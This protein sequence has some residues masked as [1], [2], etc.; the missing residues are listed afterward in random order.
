M[1]VMGNGHGRV[2]CPC[3]T[4]SKLMALILMDQSEK[5]IGV[6]NENTGLVIFWA[7]LIMRLSF[8]SIVN[9]HMQINFPIT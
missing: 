7:H 8:R 9:Q 5:V 1:P 6:T 3:D 2:P 4:W